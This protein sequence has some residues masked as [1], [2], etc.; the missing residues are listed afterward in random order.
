MAIVAILFTM[1]YALWG[2]AVYST[3]KI[4]VS[5]HFINT[6]FGIKLYFFSS[7]LYVLLLKDGKNIDASTFYWGFVWSGIAFAVSEA[8]FVL[9]IIMASNIGVTIMLTAIGVIFAYFL[10]VF[11]Y[12]E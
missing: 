7:L 10:S 11:R 4:K 5:A 9:S 3:N 1:F 12:N 6:L 2:Y 8:F